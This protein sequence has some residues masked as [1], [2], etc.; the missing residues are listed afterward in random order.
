MLDEPARALRLDGDEFLG[1]EGVAPGA[2]ATIGD[3]V[4]GHAQVV[5]D[6]VLAGRL[7]ALLLGSEV[8]LTHDVRDARLIHLDAEIVGERS[9]QTRHVIAEVFVPADPDIRLGGP[10]LVP[11][12]LAAHDESTR[13]G[14][15]L[16][17]VGLEP[18]L[19]VERCDDIPGI[20]IGVE[21]AGPGVGE[22]FAIE[23]GPEVDLGHEQVVGVGCRRRVLLG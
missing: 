19:A 10:E 14:A 9:H 1:G 7:R 11:A 15:P 21:V 12:E 13:P 3:V 4:G 18:P 5:V 2:L 16:G 6:A 22:V 23:C 17:I 20:S 8:D